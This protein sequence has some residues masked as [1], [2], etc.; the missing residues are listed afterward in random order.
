MTNTEKLH[1]E[2][3]KQV[4]AGFSN[5]E[6]RQNLLSQQFTTEEIDAAFKQSSVSAAN[7]NK[8]GKIG[9]LSLLIS[10]YFIFNGLMKMSKYPS[11][12]GMHTWG[13]ILLL[14]GVAGGIWKVADMV[15]K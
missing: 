12:S 7:G 10:I 8:A 2:I 13:I 14:A 3:E 11:G 4:A 5:P 15:R 1:I 6:I 9:F